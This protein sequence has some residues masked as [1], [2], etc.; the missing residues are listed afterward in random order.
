MR[1]IANLRSLKI[2]DGYIEKYKCEEDVKLTEKENV[3]NCENVLH[4][5]KY[6]VPSLNIQ[7]KT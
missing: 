2:Y 5:G 4:G 6:Q 7:S 3:V 1:R